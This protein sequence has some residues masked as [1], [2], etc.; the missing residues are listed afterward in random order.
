M[1]ISTAT[2]VYVNFS[3][4]ETI[5]RVAAAGYDGIDIWGGRPH[6]YRRDF[7]A[8][9]L[10]QLRS[11][12]GEV[13][14]LVPS[15]MPAFFRY[16]HSLSS[17]NETVRQDSINYMQQC[18]DNA[19]ALGA[20]TLLVVPGRRLHGQPIQDAW[21]RMVDSIVVVCQYAA[22][23]DLRLA[24]EPVNRYVSDLVNTVA[25][26]LQ[27]INQVG[28]GRLGIVLDTGHIHLSVETPSEAVARAKDRL[29]QV[30]VND[31]DGQH[32]QNLIL[33]KGSFDFNSFLETLQQ[34]G[35]DGFLTAELGWEYTL[36][37]DPA[38]R[39]TADQ[40]RRLLQGQSGR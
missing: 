23:Y 1:K 3:I 24:I 2:S 13:G 12:L 8:S 34:A 6:V 36:D 7:S 4:E 15:F 28:S 32:Q 26:A 11:L 33:G 37:P 25:D 10:Q 9:Q 17:P 35:Y 29:F 14:L 16:P 40:L 21:G 27:I 30:H 31:N 38:A 5:R 19:A 39:Q 20:G 18:A 22:Q